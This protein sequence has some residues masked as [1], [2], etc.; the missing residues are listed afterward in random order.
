MSCP[1]HPQWLHSREDCPYPHRSIKCSCQIDN[2]EKDEEQSA[3]LKRCL[4][5]WHWANTDYYRMRLSLQEDILT[6]Q[7]LDL[8]SLMPDTQTQEIL[9]YITTLREIRKKHA[10]SNPKRR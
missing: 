10:D 3:W 1:E 7:L 9:D 8:I 6:H 2:R 4:C 5:P